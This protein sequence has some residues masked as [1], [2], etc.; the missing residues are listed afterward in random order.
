MN[1]NLKTFA[2][3]LGLV[4]SLWAGYVSISNET[5]FTLNI[6][7]DGEYKGT[8][9]PGNT[10]YINVYGGSAKIYAEASGGYWG[11]RTVEEGEKIA[12]TDLYYEKESEVKPKTIA[13]KI[14]LCK[15]VTI[16]VPES[17]PFLMEGISDSTKNKI[18]LKFV[19][20]KSNQITDED[21]WYKE[22]NLNPK[23][24]A[25]ALSDSTIPESTK[26]GKLA[27]ARRYDDYIILIYGIRQIIKLEEFTIHYK[28]TL[29]VCDNSLSEVKFAYDMEQ[30]FPGEYEAHQ[31]EMVGN[32]LYFNSTTNT[33]ASLSNYKT[34]YLICLDVKNGKIV[35]VT[36]PLTSNQDFAVYKD[37]IFCGYGFTDE[38]DFLFVVNRYTGEI[39]QKIK[40]DSAP[41]T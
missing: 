7:V 4:Q 30:L 9:A 21:N 28:I 40:L 18:T 14:A 13:E 2:I 5:S 32:F 12:I 35:W 22:N 31:Y 29:L 36:P 3:I 10:A 6:Y 15:P 39:I 19:S 38:D 27:W 17:V 20:K 33:Y 24:P 41:E 34:A 8:L 23:P 25:I 1:I 11:P 37:V 26:F 16:V